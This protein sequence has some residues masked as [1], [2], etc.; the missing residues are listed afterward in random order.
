MRLERPRWLD[1]SSSAGAGLAAVVETGVK[2]MMGRRGAVVIALAGLFVTASSVS[3]SA[4]VVKT[5]K[6]R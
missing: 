3:V 2:I 5:G 6:F 1:P 4:I